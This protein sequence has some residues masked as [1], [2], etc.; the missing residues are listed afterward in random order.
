MK[1]DRLLYGLI[2]AVIGALFLY[3]IY[4]GT[5]A[6]LR[7]LS[8]YSV[9]LEVIY[10]FGVMVFADFLGFLLAKIILRGALIKWGYSPNRRNSRKSMLAHR[11]EYFFYT[12]M[13]TIALITMFVWILSAYLYDNLPA[14]WYTISFLISWLSIIIGAQIIAWAITNAMFPM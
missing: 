2:K 13:R 10:V 4:L 12:L 8:Y 6:G 3:A 7:S 5:V 1:L 11:L 9:P 14:P